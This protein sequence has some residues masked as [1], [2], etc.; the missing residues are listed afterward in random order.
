MKVPVLCLRKSQSSKRLVKMMTDSSL[1][2]D[3]LKTDITSIRV[4]ISYY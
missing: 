4:S 3:D 2:F 1:R